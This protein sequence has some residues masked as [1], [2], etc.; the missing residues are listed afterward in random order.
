[1]VH[2]HIPWSSPGVDRL[3]SADQSLV[4]WVV[5]LQMHSQMIGAEL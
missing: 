1:M 5:N 4:G 3:G 2:L